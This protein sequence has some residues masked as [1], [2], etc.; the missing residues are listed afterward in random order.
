MSVNE[1]IDFIFENYY[2]RTGFSQKSS[3]Y[4]MKHREKKYLQL[5]STKLIEKIAD[6]RNAK[7]H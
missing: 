7:V 3:Y 1:I 5:F 2:K 6:P 4:S